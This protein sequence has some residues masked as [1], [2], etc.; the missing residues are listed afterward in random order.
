M[1]PVDVKQST[2]IDFGKKNNKE[3]PKFKVGDNIRISNIK[4]F[5]Q[6]VTFQID[7]K[8]KNTVPWTYVISDLNSEEII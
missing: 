7:L 8:V 4:T 5:L 3:G 2:Y 6:K 1:K